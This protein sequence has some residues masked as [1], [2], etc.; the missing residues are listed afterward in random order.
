MNNEINFYE[1]DESIVKALAPLAIKIINE[2]KKVLIYCAL[3]SQMQEL[4]KSLWSYGRSKFIAHIT[5]NDQEFEM[6][7][8]P[9][10]IWVKPGCIL[11]LQI[12]RWK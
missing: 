4:D 9:I 1:V 6:L 3:E 12:L 2:G 5:I 11:C 10:L 7:R 8:Q